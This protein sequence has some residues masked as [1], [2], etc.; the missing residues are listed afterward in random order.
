MHERSR[1]GATVVCGGELCDV[2]HV[3]AAAVAA[4]AAVDIAVVAAA[5]AVAAAATLS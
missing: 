1:P 2:R 5:A 4:A 3:A